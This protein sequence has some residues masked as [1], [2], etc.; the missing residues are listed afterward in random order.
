MSLQKKINKLKREPKLFFKDMFLKR[1]IPLKNKL[2][3]ITPKK[4]YGY[5]K[6]AIVSAVYNVEKYL[7][8]YFKSIINQRLDFKHNIHII[9]VDEEEFFNSH[10]YTKGY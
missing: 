9:L 3:S 7:D 8:D 4:R 5:C 2:K 6:Y 10:T 1:Y